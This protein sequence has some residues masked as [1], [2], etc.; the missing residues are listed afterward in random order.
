VQA[1]D[2]EEEGDDDDGNGEDE[3]EEEEE[4]GKR[5][6]SLW[7]IKKDACWTLLIGILLV[8]VFS[9][10]MVDVLSE[11]A[12]RINVPAFYVS[13]LITPVISNASEVISGVIQ[14]SKKKQANLDVSYSQFLGAATMNN[15][16]V[17]AV[18]LL[19]VF[20]RGL[21]W[22]FS[23]E[24]LAIILVQLAVAA[25]VLTDKNGVTPLWK[26]LLAGCLFPLSLVFVYVFENV[27]HWD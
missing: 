21:A 18:F 15:T 20:A 7:Q 5:G 23:A 1:A 17:L 8:T 2:D 25:L 14:A 26:G 6:R 12:E 9:D 24:V 13:F 19:L 22:E 4:D 27:L 3:A 10:P 11:A 16:F